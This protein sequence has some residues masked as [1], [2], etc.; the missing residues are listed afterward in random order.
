MG[1]LFFSSAHLSGVVHGISFAQWA[2]SFRTQHLV[3]QMKSCFLMFAQDI[4]RLNVNWNTPWLCTLAPAGLV[5]I[6]W[7]GEWCF[8]FFPR[9]P[10]GVLFIRPGADHYSLTPSYLLGKSPKGELTECF[11]FW[12]LVLDQTRPEAERGT[13]G[14]TSRDKSVIMQS[15][16]RYLCLESHAL[17]EE[18][19]AAPSFTRATINYSGI[20]CGSFA[21]AAANVRRTFTGWMRRKS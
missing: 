12:M 8:L 9:S 13:E 17:Y 21:A 19:K 15:G 7:E 16:L 18:E 3:V 4:L 20:R 10:A 6:S 2:A 11:S 14:A 1:V 5:N